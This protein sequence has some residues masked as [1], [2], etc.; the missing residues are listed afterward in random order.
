MAFRLLGISLALPF[1]HISRKKISISGRKCPAK[2]P[3]KS[4]YIK[5]KTCHFLWPDFCIRGPN[6][7]L[8]VPRCGTSGFQAVAFPVYQTWHFRL[9]GGF[10]GEPTGQRQSRAKSSI[11]EKG[12]CKKIEYFS[13][14][15]WSNYSGSLSTV[16]LNL[17]WVS[18]L[19]IIHLNLNTSQ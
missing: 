2:G 16:I 5:A 1:L 13:L 7:A 9:R 6:H 10:M 14:F 4:G 18:D 11:L 3:A 8:P 12:P 15:D 17:L 19:T